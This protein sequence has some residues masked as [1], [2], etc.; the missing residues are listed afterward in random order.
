MSKIILSSLACLSLAYSVDTFTDIFKEGK[1]YGNIKYYYIQTDKQNNQPFKD[2]SANANAMGG[3]L[4]FKTAAYYGMSGQATFM[5][6]NG[7]HLENSV[8]TSILSRDSGVRLDNGNPSGKIAQESF[9]VLGEA[10]I[11]YH[12]ENLNIKYGRQIL[13]T[14]LI[15]AKE[16]RMLPSTV[17]GTTIKY[18]LKDTNFVFGAAYL[19]AFKQ[20]TSYKFIN[21][22][23]HTLG[24]N[25]KKITGKHSGNLYMVNMNYDNNHLHA[26]LYDY[27]AE[28]FLNS[29]YGK[30]EYTGVE[31]KYIYNL[32][33]EGIVQ[34]SI[35]N[36]NEYLAQT[37]SMTNAKKINAES[38]S[39]KSEL[40]YEESKFMLGYSYVT[41]DDTSHDSLVLP[42]DG[43]PL[44]TNMI[45]SNDLFVSNY[46]KGLVADSICQVSPRY[47]IAKAIF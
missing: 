9:S 21:I 38:I 45:T 16:V 43:T 37:D 28:N 6:T 44:Y 11:N 22:I 36:T 4:G 3:T 31:G 42:W 27:Y 2:S 1:T 8:D 41:S 39:M 18:T 30:L 26:S 12:D 17:Q 47:T 34:R 32:G 23:K 29:W 14:P 35:G 13:K 10:F 46:G 33:L 7:F 5:T 19:S 20:R 24:S 15:N 25:T 40:Q